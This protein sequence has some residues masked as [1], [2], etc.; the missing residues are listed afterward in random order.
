MANHEY[1]IYIR[2]RHGNSRKSLGDLTS[3]DVMDFGDAKVCSLSRAGGYM[4]SGSMNFSR[5]SPSE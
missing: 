5:A 4:M 2:I 3:G 1:G